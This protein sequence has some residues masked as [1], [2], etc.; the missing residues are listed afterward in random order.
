MEDATLEKIYL[1]FLK[2]NPTIEHTRKSSERRSNDFF[3]GYTG[4]RIIGCP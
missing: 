3:H 1:D 4:R 2:N